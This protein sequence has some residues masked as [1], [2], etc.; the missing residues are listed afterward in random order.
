MASLAI[1]ATYWNEADWIKSSLEQIA[2]LDPDFIVICE[3][4]FDPKYDIHSYDGTRELIQEWVARRKNVEV[5]APVRKTKIEYLRNLNF[6]KSDS[7]ALPFLTRMRLVK[8]ILRSHLY[9]L[10]QAATFAKMARIIGSR[11]K[12][13]LPNWLMACDADQFYS[14]DLISYIAKLDDLKIDGLQICATEKT[15]FHNFRDYTT[16]YES[17]IWN[18]LPFQ[19]ESGMVVLP[20][21][22]FAYRRGY[23]HVFTYEEK[24]AKTGLQ[25]MHYK[26][27][28]AKSRDD[29]TY[30]LGDRK[31]PA[32]IRTN[33]PYERCEIDEHNQIVQSLIKD[34][35]GAQFADSDLQ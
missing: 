31:P 12:P 19:F 7:K 5:I 35:W 26:F 16:K 27:R 29:L 33:G 10:N 9:R 30:N 6:F 24:L 34:G 13:N 15:F 4:N 14:D 17:R 23:R 2:A 20:T 21:R 28:L 22:H 32:Q 18:N 8:L 1:M 3:G 25:Y 11:T